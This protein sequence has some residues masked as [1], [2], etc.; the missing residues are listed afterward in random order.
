MA[1]IYKLEGN[2]VTPE[3]TCKWFFC[4]TSSA[5]TLFDAWSTDRW[6]NGEPN[7]EL[8]TWPPR[9]HLRLQ[10]ITTPFEVFSKKTHTKIHQDRNEM[11]TA[12]LHNTCSGWC[13]WREYRLK[14]AC[15]LWSCDE[16]V[17]L[18]FVGC[19]CY[20]VVCL[21]YIQ[22]DRFHIMYNLHTCL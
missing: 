3:C 20:V 10:L 22:V 12:S 1:Q 19:V 13:V 16:R 11:H 18:L 6:P 21:V 9:P 15:L 2:R 17:V 14:W 5:W 4:L 8:C 7:L